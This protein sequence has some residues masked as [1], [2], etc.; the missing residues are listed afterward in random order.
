MNNKIILTIICLF[1]SLAFN[2]STA[3]EKGFINKKLGNIIFIDIPEYMTKTYGL[4]DV[5]KAQYQNTD[6]EAYLIIIEEEKEDIKI[7]GGG[8]ANS[9]EY[10]KFFVESFGID[11]IK[12]MSG[13]EMNK[14]K[15]PAYQGQ[16]E[17]FVNGLKLFYLVTIVESP[18]HFYNII[19]WTLFERKSDV[20][21]DF[22]KIASSLKE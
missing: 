10:F 11:S 15:F 5:A 8:F 16:I 21:N 1:V 14:G 13:E 19:S 12:I 2:V 7:A 17:G 6:K 20:I 9:K 4:N 3:Q 22:K 18:T